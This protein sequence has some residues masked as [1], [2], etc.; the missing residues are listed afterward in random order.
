MKAESNALSGMIS[1]TF[2]LENLCRLK[3]NDLIKREWKGLLR[4]K[5]P[6]F[7][8][9]LLFILNTSYFYVHLLQ[10]KEHHTSIIIYT[11]SVHITTITL[12]ALI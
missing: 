3:T 1:V 12:H 11:I 9:A 2:L 7:P 6:D 4:Q 5:K 8:N 10:A